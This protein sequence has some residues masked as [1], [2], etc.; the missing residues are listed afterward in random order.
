MRETRFAACE[1]WRPILIVG[2]I[3]SPFGG[4]VEEEAAYAVFPGALGRQRQSHEVVASVELGPAV[5][6]FGRHRRRSYVTSDARQ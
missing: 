1:G 3:P 4:D 6:E 2:M 5:R